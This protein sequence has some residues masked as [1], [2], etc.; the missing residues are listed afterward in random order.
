MKISKIFI[1]SWLYIICDANL[2]PDVFVRES[3]V[4]GNGPGFTA[5]HVL[6]VSIKRACIRIDDANVATAAAGMNDI[7]FNAANLSRRALQRVD[8]PHTSL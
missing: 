4:F 2:A 7:K 6:H 8:A 3:C 1:L 5:K